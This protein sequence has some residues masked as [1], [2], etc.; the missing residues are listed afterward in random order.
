MLRRSL[1]LLVLVAG[2]ALAGCRGEKPTAEAG[3]EEVAVDN[4]RLVRERD[5][6]RAVRGV[7]INRSR[8]E[9]SVQITI[10]LYDDANQRIGE[11]QVPVEHVEA[12]AQQ[13]FSQKLDYDA[14]GASVRRILVF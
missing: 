2:V 6:S 14:T 12:G 5:G 3:A 11:V 8:E 1:V 4:L 10:S 13:G 9:Q 7:L